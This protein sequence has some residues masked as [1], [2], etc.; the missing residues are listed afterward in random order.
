MQRLAAQHNLSETAF[1]RRLAPSR[2]A[3]RWFT[4]EQ[5]VD[6]CGHATLAAAFVALTLDSGG[7]SL[8]FETRSGDLPVRLLPTGALELDFPCRPATP[9]PPS[10]W[11]PTLLAA[12]R[13]S[14]A[15]VVCMG[16]ARDYL[17][18][19][20]TPAQVAAV[21]PDFEKLAAI[22]ALCVIVA[23]RGRPCSCPVEVLRGGCHCF[24]AGAT[25]V[26]GDSNAPAADVVSRVFCPGCGVPEDPVTG[27]AHCT[28]A[29]HFAAIL[30][31]QVLS[32]EQVSSRGGA[33]RAEL[34]EGGRVALAGRCTLYMRGEVEAAALEGGV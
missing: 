13:L 25:P 6:L 8:V 12:L 2:Y 26:H 28:I 1:Y 5:E 30:Q 14:A 27:S 29:P 19:V 32:C 34:R 22:D 9:I 33:L 15:E 20:A 10:D 16:K 21:K 17:V 18:E 4:P 11:P 23:A 24:A 31:T 3:L 7:D